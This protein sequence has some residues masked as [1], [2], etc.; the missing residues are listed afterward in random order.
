MVDGGKHQVSSVAGPRHHRT[1]RG[2]SRH[3]HS[4]SEEDGAATGGGRGR[5]GKER[6]RDVRRVPAS[7]RSPVT[8]SD[9]DSDISDGEGGTPSLLRCI[10]S[11]AYCCHVFIITGYYGV[12]CVT[13]HWC[14]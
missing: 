8:T 12:E 4:G 14:V 10:S 3:D 1:S 6:R 5:R 11:I 7:Q 13:N 9:S 2:R